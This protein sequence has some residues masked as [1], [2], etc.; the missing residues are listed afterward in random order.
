MSYALNLVAPGPALG[1]RHLC[2]HGGLIYVCNDAGW[3]NVFNGSAWVDVTGANLFVGAEHP[4][5]VSA[6]GSLYLINRGN[7]F[8]DANRGIWKWDGATSWVSLNFLTSYASYAPSTGIDF[9]GELHIGITT[10]V[11]STPTQQIIK[12]NGSAFSTVVAGYSQP[13]STWPPQLVVVGASLYA[14]DQTGTLYLVSSGALSAVSASSVPPTTGEAGDTHSLLVM[15]GVLYMGSQSINTGLGSLYRWDGV[16][17]WV[18]LIAY[19]SANKCMQG[20]A[21]NGF[22]NYLQFSPGTGFFQF[23]GVSAF[24]VPK[25]LA[26]AVFSQARSIGSQAWMLNIANE[27]L[28]EIVYT[29]PPPASMFIPVTIPGITG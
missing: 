20:F 26:G 8:L 15:G 27:G 16:S 6:G 13:T 23:N 7:S 9:G 29:A 18:Q 21:F 3:L 17:A 11:N 22:V 1:M 12:W 4:N 28:Y 5:M 24:T 25:S 10:D 14:C 2:V 19:A